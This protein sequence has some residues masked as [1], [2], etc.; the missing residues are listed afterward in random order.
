MAYTKIFPIKKTL[1][2]AIDYICDKNK[3][4]D[5]LLISSENCLFEN[6][7]KSFIETRE[8]YNTKGT[9]L[10]RHLIQSFK[11]KEVDLEK[12]HEI[13]KKLCKELFKGE[14]QYILST[15]V[16]KG[17]I[18]NHIILNNVNS[19]TGYCYRSNKKTYHDLRK[20]SDKICKENNL[21]VIDEI[22][23]EYERRYKT[24]GKSWYEYQEHKKGTSWKSKMQFDIDRFILKANTF[25][26]FLTYMK[27]EGYE[28]KQGNVKYMAFKAKDQKRFT[29]AKSIG[30]DY[31]EDR[32]KERISEMNEKTKAFSDKKIEK[33][34][35]IDNSKKAKESKGYAFW[36]AKHN[37]KTIAENRILMKN[38]GIDSY[39]DL[40]EKI[41][42]KEK[43][44]NDIRSEIKDIT[45]KIEILKEDMDNIYIVKNFQ[46]IYNDFL[47]LKEDDLFKNE[48]KEEIE[49][50]KEA[51]EFLINKYGKDK[52]PSPE[53]IL[54]KLNERDDICKEKMK[55]LEEESQS[56]FKM[57]ELYKNYEGY[58]KINTKEKNRD[59]EL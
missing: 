44:L 39:S 17:H 48:Y 2:K 16:D 20:L 56:L 36:A 31:T 49:K 54:K 3:T 57:K 15:H 40:K 42:L 53:I 24:K 25:S 30:E 50:Y 43:E 47:L 28:I 18:H 11:P 33:I 8:K 29:R 10:A 34:I 6:A 12:A 58:M 46:S 1:Q 5:Q 59:P 45:A 7:Y 51:K 38:M 41:N 35:D 27:K 13:G 23:N 37:L 19:N 14:Y 52:I 32:I 55:I 22:F 26:E 21:S 4:C 9:V